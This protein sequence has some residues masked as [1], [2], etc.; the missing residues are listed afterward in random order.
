MYKAYQGIEQKT[1]D[2]PLPM[3]CFLDIFYT[4]L[5]IF[6]YTHL[7]VCVYIQQIL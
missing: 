5:Y 4:H 3:L 2:M 6:I 1:K 7:Y